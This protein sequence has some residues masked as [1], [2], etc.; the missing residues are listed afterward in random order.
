[1]GAAPTLL[2]ICDGNPVMNFPNNR[3]V[4]QT[5]YIFILGSLYEH[6]VEHTVELPVI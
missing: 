5:F 1:M 6:A 4:L 2:V 3:A